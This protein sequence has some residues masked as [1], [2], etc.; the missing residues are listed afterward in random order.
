MGA[1]AVK[2]INQDVGIHQVQVIGDFLMQKMPIIQQLPT[3]THILPASNETD[4]PFALWA[5]NL[6]S[7]IL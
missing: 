3:C 5:G 1:S 7:T 4:S 2:R 6:H